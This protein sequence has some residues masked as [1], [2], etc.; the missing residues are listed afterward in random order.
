MTTEDK[1]LNKFFAGRRPTENDFFEENNKYT[2]EWAVKVIYWCFP[3]WSRWLFMIISWFM[4]NMFHHSQVFCCWYHGKNH[5]TITGFNRIGKDFL[6]GYFKKRTA[7]LEYQDLPIITM[8]CTTNDSNILL[9][10]FFWKKKCRA[11]FELRR[12]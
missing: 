8:L 1:L 10:I 12:L 6:W 4:S 3:W 5:S 2:A 9:G 11:F 7:C